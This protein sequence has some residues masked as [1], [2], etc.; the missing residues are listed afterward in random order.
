MGHHC[1]C[2]LNL[3]F[4]VLQAVRPMKE[5]LLVD[6]HEGPWVHESPHWM[7][8]C[9]AGPM[10]IEQA[11]LFVFAPLVILVHAAPRL[12]R[13]LRHFPGVLFEEIVYL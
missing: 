13:A 6:R 2:Q 7:S 9:S 10:L 3:S 1:F 12:P 11:Q 5:L 8:D 4:L